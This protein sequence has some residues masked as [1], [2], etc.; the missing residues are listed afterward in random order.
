[1][2][3][4]VKGGLHGVSLAVAF[5]PA[6]LSAFGRVEKM[7]VLFAQAFALAPGIV[8]DYLRI[9]YYKWTLDKCAL[10]SRIQFGSFFAHAQAQVGSGVYIG[11]WCILGR[12]A[13]GDRTQI[14]SGVQ[15]LSGRRQH[16]RDGEGRILGS[17]P[18]EFQSV[19]IG[20]DCWIGAA[21]IVMAEVGAGSTVGAGSIVVKPIP[22]RSVAVGNP[23]RV[24]KATEPESGGQ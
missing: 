17:D 20:A 5:L 6:L 16:A 12:T 2:K 4:L 14:A 24:V 22:A 7:F 8:G 13:I 9:A 10:D 18:A 1:M 15:I 11:S 21:A 19:T 23:A 3:K